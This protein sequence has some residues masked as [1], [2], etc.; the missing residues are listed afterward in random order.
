M[1]EA[2]LFTKKEDGADAKNVPE[3]VQ[4]C[5]DCLRGFVEDSDQNL[6][7]LGEYGDGLYLC[8][9]SRVCT[10]YLLTGLVGLVDLMKSHPRVVV[11]HR[12]IVFRCL[13]DSDATV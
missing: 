4:V 10:F 6:K 12:D 5:S 7:Y 11:E 3:V 9:Y 13:G 2:L 1:T 8:G